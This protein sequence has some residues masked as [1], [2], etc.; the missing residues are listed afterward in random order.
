MGKWCIKEGALDWVG[1]VLDTMASLSI[2]VI[3]SRYLYYAERWLFKPEL[4]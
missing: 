1:G 2:A 3:A 4:L